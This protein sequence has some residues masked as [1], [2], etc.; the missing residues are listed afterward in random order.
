MNQNP[1][2]LHASSCSASEALAWMRNICG[3]H[4]LQASDRAP[5][6]FSHHGVRLPGYGAVLGEISYGTAVRLQLDEVEALQAYSISL[7]LQG[8]QQLCGSGVR[9][10]SA[11]HCGLVISP[12]APLQLD[13][14]SGCRKLQLVLPRTAVMKEAGQLLGQALTTPLQFQP[15]MPMQCA[16]VAAWWQSLLHLHQHWPQ[17]AALYTQPPMAQ[18]L[19]QMLIRG[20]LL[21][22]PHNYSAALQAAPALAD[23]QPAYL[24]RAC[25][26]MR[27]HAAEEIS[28]EAVEQVAGVSRLKLYEAFRR[29][30][31]TSPMVWL[32]QYRLQGVQQALAHPDAHTSVSATALAW[33]FNHLGRFASAYASTYD[34]LPSQTLALARQT[35]G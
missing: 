28:I 29:Y 27:S 34:E 5:V 26:F 2:T 4:R 8:A 30:L 7:P 22:Q 32:R 16:A 19:E 9:W 18:T 13:M 21:V 3:P 23:T 31:H 24:L 15:D 6:V 14:D 10:R 1:L 11:R 12:A 20:L 25:Q 17:L 33:G 35:A